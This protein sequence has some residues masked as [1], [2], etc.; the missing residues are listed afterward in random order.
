MFEADL[1]DFVTLKEGQGFAVS[2]ANLTTVGG[3]T[4][5][6]IKNYIKTQYLGANPPDYVILV[7][8]YYPGNAADLTNWDFRSDDYGNYRTDLHYYTMDN[9]TEFVP[10]I[11]GGRFPVRTVAQLTAMIDKY[12]A[13]QDLSGVEPWIKKAEF[14][15]SNDGSYYDVAEASHN[16]VINSYTLPHGYTG[17]FPNNP[18]PGGD[19][20]YAITYGGTGAHAVASMNDDRAFIQWNR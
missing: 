1:A 2:V 17:I 6:A 16:Y 5:T 18:Q 8:D 15:A 10:D 11:F 9:D 7:G 12:L 4:T 14:L 13:Y 3:N 19:K 20:I